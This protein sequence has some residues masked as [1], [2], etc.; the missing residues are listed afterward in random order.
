MR[1]CELVVKRWSAPRRR[2]VAVPVLRGEAMALM[3]RLPVGRQGRRRCRSRV[4][5]RPP[6]RCGEGLRRHPRSA[7]DVRLAETPGAIV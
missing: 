3:S 7:E 5:V 4:G 6:H 1:Q 2:K